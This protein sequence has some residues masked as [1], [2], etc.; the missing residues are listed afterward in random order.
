MFT[1]AHAGFQALL[2]LSDL[3]EAVIGPGED[4]GER[5]VFD[6]GRL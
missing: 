4:D 1:G 3:F 5:A 6:G 2:C